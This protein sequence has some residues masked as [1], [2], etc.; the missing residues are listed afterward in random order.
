MSKFGGLVMPWLKKSFVSRENL[1]EEKGAQVQQQLPSDDDE[2]DN[3]RRGS[4]TQPKVGELRPGEAETGGLGRHLGLFSTTFL[5]IGRIIGTGIFSTPSSITAGVGSVG[6]A[7]M[8]WFLGL[9]IAFAGLFIWLELGC[10][11]PRSGGEKVYLEAAF[12]YPK[13]LATTVF[14]FQIVLLG[15][16]ASGCI[17]FTTYVSCIHTEML[18]SSCS[19]DTISFLRRSTPQPTKQQPTGKSEASRSSSL[20]SFAV[21]TPS[22]LTPVCAS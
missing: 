2:F 22:Y 4:T 15:F 19:T 16:T 3:H 21:S 5:I 20:L 10:M 14:A 12:K 18:L 8:L 9:A 13:L 1:G 7:M 17:V 6:A 11:I